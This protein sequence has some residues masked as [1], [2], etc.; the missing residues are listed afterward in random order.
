MTLIVAVLSLSSASVRVLIIAGMEQPKPIIIGINALPE[1]PN[2]RKILSRMNAT[3]AIYPLSSR[4]LKNMNSTR[5]CGRKDKTENKPPSMPSHTSP[6]A[7][8]EVAPSI[9]PLTASE[10]DPVI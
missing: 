8:A 9:A 2:L 1:S 5:I 4:M 6:C 3:R 10:I 7:H